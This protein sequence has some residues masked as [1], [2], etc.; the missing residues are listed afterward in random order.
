MA[1]EDEIVPE[2]P[3]EAEAEAVREE[4]PVP[5]PE[6]EPAEAAEET[7]QPELDRHLRT[8]DED[9]LKGV[10]WATLKTEL[11]LRCP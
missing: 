8:L 3:V 6:A 4:T 10:T 7:P 1:N 2:E 9:R 5:Q 11:E